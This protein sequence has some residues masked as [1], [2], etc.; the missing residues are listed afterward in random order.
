M[1]NNDGIC[2]ETSSS[3][4]SLI[5]IYKFISEL[6]YSRT[7]DQ[8]FH[9]ITHVRYFYP[10]YLYQLVGK[11]KVEQPNAGRMSIRDVIVM[12]NDVI[13]SFL[14]V[15]RI[16][17]SFFHVFPNKIEVFSG[18]QEKNP[19]FVWGWDRKI[20]PTWSPFVITRQT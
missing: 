10:T 3:K 6:V 4:P 13:M 14:S 1:K 16:F 19:L 12:L 11:I 17:R 2:R 20:C 5:F 7:P 8:D 9:V 18:E 15:F